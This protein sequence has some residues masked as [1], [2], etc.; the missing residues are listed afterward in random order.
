MK[1]IMKK[2]SLSVKEFSRIH[3]IDQFSVYRGIWAG[4]IK[5][6]KINRNWFI[7]ET[8]SENFKKY[9]KHKTCKEVK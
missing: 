9:G 2:I 3:E 4:R 1:K 5:A 7:S 6:T 8:E